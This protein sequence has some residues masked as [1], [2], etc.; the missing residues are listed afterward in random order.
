MYK[1]I[2]HLTISVTLIVDLI[3]PSILYLLPFRY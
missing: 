2:Y 3:W 1:H